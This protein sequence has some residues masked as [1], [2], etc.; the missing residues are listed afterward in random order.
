M[1]LSVIIKNKSI[2]LANI[3][4]KFILVGLGTVIFS[5]VLLFSLTTQVLTV[6]CSIII[7]LS[8]T[9]FFSQKLAQKEKT[10]NI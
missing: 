7:V 9:Y 3:K 6:G 2:V 5:L 4:K 1:L 10:K 8:L